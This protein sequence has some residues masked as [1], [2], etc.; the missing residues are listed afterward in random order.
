L[1]K[2]KDELEINHRFNDFMYSS[3][4][5]KKKQQ[6][7]TKKNAKKF[8]FSICIIWLIYI[9]FLF[10]FRKSLLTQMLF[11]FFTILGLKI[12]K[13]NLKF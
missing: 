12:I 10:K 4:L 3:I 5:G 11:I 7:N 2:Q 13:I 1:T 9:H 6:L 8:F